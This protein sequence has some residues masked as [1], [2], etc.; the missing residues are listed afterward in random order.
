VLKTHL[1]QR[2]GAK[3]LLEDMTIQ[4]YGVTYDELE[5]YYNQFEYLCGTSGTAGNLQGKIQP[6]GNSFEGARSRPYPTPAMKQPYGPIAWAEAAKEIWVISHSRS[7][8]GIYRRHTQTPTASP[9]VP[10]HAVASASRSAAPTTRRPA[11]KRRL[12]W[13]PG[14]D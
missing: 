1:T 3:F 5:P 13:R 7:H 9:W 8:P 10:A 2:Y 4:D 6:F 11:R 14:T 12:L